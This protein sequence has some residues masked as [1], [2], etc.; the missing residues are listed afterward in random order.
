MLEVLTHYPRNSIDLRMTS[1][2]AL[3]FEEKPDPFDMECGRIKGEKNLY[4]IRIG[5]YRVRYKVFHR[6][7]L[8]FIL[9]VAP[10]GKIRY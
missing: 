5:K 7:N 3:G 6:K 10:R 1:S 4:R 8:I 2:R 9:E